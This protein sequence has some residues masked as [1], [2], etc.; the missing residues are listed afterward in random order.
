ME[1]LAALATS[2]HA[3]AALVDAGTRRGAG[4]VIATA[5]RDAGADAAARERAE[6]GRE[7]AAGHLRALFARAPRLRAAC[8]EGIRELAIDLGDG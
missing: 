6:A 4:R 5:L 8:A 2:A 7:R 1:L 3:R